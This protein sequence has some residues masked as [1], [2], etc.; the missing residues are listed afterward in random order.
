[1][2]NRSIKVWCLVH[3]WTSLICTLFM[4]LLCLTGLPLIFHDEIDHLFEEDRLPPMPADTPLKNLDEAV[5]AALAAY[6]GERGLFLSFDVDRPV[7]NV[8]TGPTAGASR[9]EMHISAI[10]RRTTQIVGDLND[11]SGFMHVMLRLHVDLF[12]GLPGEL[13]LGFMGFLLVVATVS[14]VVVYAPFMRKLRFGTVRTTRSARLKWLD[15]HNLLGI[16]T[17]MWVGVVGLTGVINTLS[18]PLVAYWR[19]DQLAAMIAPYKDKPVPERFVSLDAA[20]R[21]AMAAAPGTRPQFVAFP[22]VRFSSNHHYAVWLKGATPATN[23]ILTPALID[24]ETGALT[25]M[26]SMPWYML[27][28][29]LSQPLHFGDYGG[30]PLKLLWAALDLAAIVILG[31]G[32]YLWIVRRRTSV[33]TRLKDLDGA[34]TLRA[35]AAE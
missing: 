32:L 27:A 17:L 9:K 2:T 1:M 16:V 20:V 25:E 34:G 19:S 33:E 3:K 28:L 23:R 26:R 31:S 4:L 5:A 30:L 29:R 15:L 14:G 7:V 12:A 22:G 13:F 18:V 21:T 8:T 11:E 24:A 10:D 35:G 6:P